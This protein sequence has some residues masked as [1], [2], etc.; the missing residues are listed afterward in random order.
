MKPIPPLGASEPSRDRRQMPRQEPVG[1]SLTLVEIL[2][3][4]KRSSHAEAAFE[5]GLDNSYAKD[6][7]HSDHLFFAEDPV[8]DRLV[9]HV[10]REKLPGL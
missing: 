6:A 5:R 2:Y 1:W 7:S 8:H 10:L 4:W 9:R 3:F